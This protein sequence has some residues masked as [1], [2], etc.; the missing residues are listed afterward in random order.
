MRGKF[1]DEAKLSFLRAARDKIAEAARHLDML[2]NDD[3]ELAEAINAIPDQGG[4]EGI[5]KSI[6][7]I[8][9]ERAEASK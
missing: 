3:P 4:L 7:A 5:A 8:A 2:A 9:R 1:T 6:G